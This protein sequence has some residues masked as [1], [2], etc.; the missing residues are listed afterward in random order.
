M[1]QET[2]KIILPPDTSS[3]TKEFDLK[4]KKTVQV[5]LFQETDNPD[6]R[7]NITI[8]D[9]GDIALLKKQPIQNVRSRDGGYNDN[10]PFVVQQ[11]TVKVV[12]DCNGI[13][14]DEAVFTL[15]VDVEGD[16]ISY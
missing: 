16:I 12:I 1:H 13:S 14:V 3:I 8:T 6:N 9:A 11:K 15:V 4:G 2:L 10:C 7:Y 5:Q